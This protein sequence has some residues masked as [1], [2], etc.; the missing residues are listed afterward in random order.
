MAADVPASVGGRQDEPLFRWVVK[1]DQYGREYKELV[2]VSPE[3]P[4]PMPRQVINAQP[5]W[6][7]DEQSGRMYRGQSP[8][9]NT[10]PV[11]KVVNSHHHVY[12]VLLHL[13]TLDSLAVLPHL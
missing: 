10:D 7:Y 4:P 13:Q 6:Y 9:P 8:A 1:R 12:L 2:E 3:R 11:L 5:G